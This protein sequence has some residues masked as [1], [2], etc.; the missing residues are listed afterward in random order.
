MDNH[1]LADTLFGLARIHQ[2]EQGLLSRPFSSLLRAVLVQILERQW[3]DLADVATL[4]RS[5]L[6]LN[7][8]KNH[9]QISAHLV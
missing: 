1:S 5:A 4:A 6:S 3:L 9:A 2:Q 8:L 7:L